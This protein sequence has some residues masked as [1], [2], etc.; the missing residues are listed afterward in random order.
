M[1]VGGG[2]VDIKIEGYCILCCWC[3][4]VTMDQKFSF[5]YIMSIVC[6]EI[7]YCASRIAV[8]MLEQNNARTHRFH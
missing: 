8:I 3:Y 4:M 7:L 5:M 6:S 1:I 2:H